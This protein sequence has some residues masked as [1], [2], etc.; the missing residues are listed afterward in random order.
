MYIFF[1]WKNH[2]VN[3]GHKKVT[4]L[5]SSTDIAHIKKLLIVQLSLNVRYWA[6]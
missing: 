4:H 5:L 1:L 6:S 3:S 2:T